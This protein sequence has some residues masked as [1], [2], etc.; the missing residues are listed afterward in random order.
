MRGMYILC[1]KVYPIQNKNDRAH[2][3]KPLMICT[4]HIYK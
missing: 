4:R 2:D 1:A 3:I